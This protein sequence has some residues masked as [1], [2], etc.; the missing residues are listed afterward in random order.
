MVSVIVHADDFGL[1]EKVNEGILRAHV[2]GILTSTSIIAGGRA[3]DHAVD[4]IKANPSLDLGIHLTL[5]E[6]RP[7][8]PPEDVP[9]LLLNNGHF[10]PHAKN[11]FKSYILNKI[12]LAEIRR[13]FNAQ[14][15]KVSD[16]GLS[17]SHID[18]H[19]HIHI[20]P[21][22]FEITYELAEKYRVKQI[23]IPN[24][25]FRFYM[26]KDISSYPRLLQS[27]LLKAILRFVN[28]DLKDSPPE[29]FGFFYGGKLNRKNLKNIIDV[30]PDGGVSE[31]MC[32]PGLDDTR[33]HYL[34]WDYN[35]NDELEALTDETIHSLINRKGILL[36]SYREI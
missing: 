19:Q 33:S 31:I 9:S 20:L 1:S 22:I 29:F 36:T 34:H 25:K 15:E 23:R 17:I 3:F 12:S 2:N 26:F 11:F 10:Y 5:I 14:F 27:M 13:E 6:E 35:W 24:E 7:L 28:N 21:K 30:L 4:L 32:H 18:S 16:F 8:L